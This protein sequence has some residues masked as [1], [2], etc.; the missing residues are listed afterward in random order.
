MNDQP[1]HSAPSRASTLRARALVGA[2]AGLIIFLCA[3]G[4]FLFGGF[5][6]LSALGAGV[7]FGLPIFFS[8]MRWQAA[9]D[10]CLGL[11]EALATVC[12]AL[13][14]ALAAVL[15]ALAS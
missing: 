12:G 8:V 11:L 5:D 13:T 15:S 4:A 7:A 1:Q 2:A 14:A 9:A 6:W 10:F 3:G